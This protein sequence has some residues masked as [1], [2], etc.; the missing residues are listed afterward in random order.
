MTSDTRVTMH[1]GAAAL[2]AIALLAAGAGATYL[3]MRSDAGA[4]GHAADMPSPTGAQPPPAASA[5]H[6]QRAA[7]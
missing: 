2:V 1:K 4:G 7:L 6:E 3:L 5:R